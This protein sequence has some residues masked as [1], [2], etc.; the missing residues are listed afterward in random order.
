M[1]R[2]TQ[3]TFQQVATSDRG[4]TQT[5]SV[6]TEKNAG[7]EIKKYF[8][9]DGYLLDKYK[10]LVDTQIGNNFCHVCQKYAKNKCSQ[11]KMINYCSTACQKSHW[12][13][14][15]PMCQ[16][17]RLRNPVNHTE[18]LRKI[19]SEDKDNQEFI[20][21][22]RNY[23]E[24]C[25][26]GKQYPNV[27]SLINRWLE[28]CT[29]RAVFLLCT[30]EHVRNLDIGRVADGVLVLISKQITKEGG[31]NVKP[32]KETRVLPSGIA[33]VETY[34]VQEI[35]T[36]AMQSGDKCTHIASGMWDRHDDTSE[37]TWGDMPVRTV[38]RGAH[39]IRQPFG[40]WDVVQYEPERLRKSDSYGLGTSS[41]PE[42]IYMW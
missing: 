26:H 21:H 35:E 31:R 11:C 8:D 36:L 12:K 27:K 4:E 13:A 38:K 34:I 19:S 41:A 1:Y 17:T 16:A 39:A 9:A 40:G 32:P 3:G 22:T 20:K 25:F 15:K 2:T 23:E 5:P 18:V 28:H 30:D 10:D 29:F 37:C 33:D 14:H 42:D 6:H 24:M 7:E